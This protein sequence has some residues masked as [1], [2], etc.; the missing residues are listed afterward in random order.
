MNNLY[1]NYNLLLRIK[2]IL[3][4]VLSQSYLNLRR[5]VLCSTDQID[6]AIK[7]VVAVKYLIIERRGINKKRDVWIKRKNQLF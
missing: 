4:M 5:D 3:L 6:I 1:Q 7:E 2:I